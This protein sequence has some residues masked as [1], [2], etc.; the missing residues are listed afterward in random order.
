MN[1]T[2]TP[3]VQKV[4]ESVDQLEAAT[5]PLTISGAMRLGSSVTTQAKGWGAGDSA[6]ALAT[7]R[8]GGAASG[9]CK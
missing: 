6:C 2:E 7:A 4:M 3:Q 5:R 8:I 1:I 9:W